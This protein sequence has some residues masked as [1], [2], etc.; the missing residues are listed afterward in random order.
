MVKSVNG[1]SIRLTFERLFHITQNHPELAGKTFDILETVGQPEFIFEGAEGE[2]LAVRKMNHLY[3]VVVYR[4]QEGDGF[5][6]TAFV[7]SRTES[8]KSRKQV[9]PRSH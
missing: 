3:L 2:C 7:T 5:V 9:W 8:F 1:V 4:E 6:I